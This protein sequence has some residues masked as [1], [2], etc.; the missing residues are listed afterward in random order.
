[1]I[2]P[3]RELVHSEVDGSYTSA[4]DDKY[5]PIWTYILNYLPAKAN[6]HNSFIGAVFI[7]GNMEGSRFCVVIDPEKV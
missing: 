6:K 2:V 7:K 1:M 5:L 4:V 3:V